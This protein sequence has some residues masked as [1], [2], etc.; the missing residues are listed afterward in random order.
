MQTESCCSCSSCGETGWCWDATAPPKNRHAVQNTFVARP[1]ETSCWADT[2]DRSVAQRASSF[3]E[4]STAVA[5]TLAWSLVVV[6]LLL[7]PIFCPPGAL[8]KGKRKVQMDG[9]NSSS[10]KLASIFLLWR[11]QFL[12]DREVSLRS[13]LLS[14]AHAVQPHLENRITDCANTQINDFSCHVFHPCF[15]VDTTAPEP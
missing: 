4:A 5:P 11:F 7:Y 15:P 14:L 8:R 3:V 10:F 12:S 13:S 9:C 2:R 6:L 1:G